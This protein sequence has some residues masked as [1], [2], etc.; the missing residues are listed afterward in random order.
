MSNK[1]DFKQPDHTLYVLRDGVKLLSS[2]KEDRDGLRPI[3]EQVLG[4]DGKH[5]EWVLLN[6]DTNDVVINENMIIY[7]SIW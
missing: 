3:Y 4:A 7:K 6:E 5:F 1:Y 2:H